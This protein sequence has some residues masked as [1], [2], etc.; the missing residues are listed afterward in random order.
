MRVITG[1]PG[2]NVVVGLGLGGVGLGIGTFGTTDTEEVICPVDIVLG[3][4]G[5]DGIPG[6]IIIGTPGICKTTV[7]GGICTAAPPGLSPAAPGCTAVEEP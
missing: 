7:A 2:V 6:M 4:F 1:P 3:G 5:A